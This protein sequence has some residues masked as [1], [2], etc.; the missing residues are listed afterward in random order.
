MELAPILGSTVDNPAA[1]QPLFP[2]GTVLDFEAALKRAKDMR[3][4]PT[5][6]RVS[7]DVADSCAKDLAEAAEAFR[8]STQLAQAFQL[9]KA[10]LDL[11]SGE[12]LKLKARIDSIDKVTESLLKTFGEAVDIFKIVSHKADDNLSTKYMHQLAE[13]RR[14]V[15]TEMQDAVSRETTLL[16]ELAPAR[17]IIAA[18]AKRLIGSDEE[19]TFMSCPVCYSGV[20]DMV[21]KCGHTCCKSCIDRMPKKNCTVCRIDGEPF[22]IYFLCDTGSVSELG[23]GAGAG[24]GAGVAPSSGPMPWATA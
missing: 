18:A 8:A 23:T 17:D 1:A 19:V 2:N 16:A 15:E 7:K 10:Q 22:K 11:V 21:W 4:D 3:G 13:V 6:P 12:K 24:A 14:G 9:A 5:A 20:V